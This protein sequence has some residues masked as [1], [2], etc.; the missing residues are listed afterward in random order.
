MLC[1][2]VT[3]VAFRCRL[4]DILPE[5]VRKLLSNKELWKFAIIGVL[6]TAA[7]LTLQHYEAARHYNIVWTSMVQG[8]I[9]ANAGMIL[10]KK[11]TF[12]GR[13][14]PW[15]GV[16]ICWNLQRIP[17]FIASTAVFVLLF[18]VMNWPHTWATIV[19]TV[20]LGL[21]S[22]LMASRWSM[23]SRRAKNKA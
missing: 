17:H 3:L 22:Y 16:F 2:T 8:S 13:S 23:R 14:L 4:W 10:N 7:Q 12:Q 15:L 9:L 1:A 20:S 6:M 21:G 19:T 5:P 18:S 11:W